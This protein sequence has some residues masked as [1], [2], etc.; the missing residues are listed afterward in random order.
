MQEVNLLSFTDII[1][2]KTLKPYFR[3]LLRV[4]QRNSRLIMP[5][6]S[7]RSPDSIPRDLLRME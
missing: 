3:F 2:Q 1:F 6:L 5:P 4:N 7:R